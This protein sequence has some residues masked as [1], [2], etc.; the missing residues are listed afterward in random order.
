MEDRMRLDQ[1]TPNLEHEIAM[2]DS[3]KPNASATAIFMGI[4]IY[5]IRN[6]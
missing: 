4:L 5:A 2:S 6:L 3:L 1:I